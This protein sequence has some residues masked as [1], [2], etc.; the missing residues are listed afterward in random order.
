MKWQG[1]ALFG[2]TLMLAGCVDAQAESSDGDGQDQSH[3]G[4][5]GIAINA[6]IDASAET[7]VTQMRYGIVR[8]ACAAD[9]Q[10][11][12]LSRDIQVDLQ[13]IML[14]GGVPALDE[15]PL[16]R[17]SQHRFADHFELLPAGCYDVTATPLG[18]DAAASQDCA[19][20]RVNRVQVQDGLTSE[21]FLVSQCKGAEMGSVDAVVALNQPPQLTNLTFSPSKF[22]RAGETTT[23]CATAIDPNGDAME[24]EWSQV[25]GDLGTGE[26]TTATN[27]DGSTTQCAPIGP[28]DP[29]DYEFEVRIYDVIRDEN[30]NP[31]RVERWLSE[32]GYPSDSH[33][34]LRFPVHVGAAAPT[35][36][37]E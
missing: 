2:A 23:V 29:G 14:P 17:G 26:V 5:T 21:V 19:V 20:A 4:E 27:Q 37:G 8:V 9:E 7:D 12:P 32:H 15:G 22:I 25:G 31:I 34:S 16:A 35:Q 28:A 36:T 33:D 10:F 30:N 13:T 3:V 6:A 24:L 11:E 1:F 18:V